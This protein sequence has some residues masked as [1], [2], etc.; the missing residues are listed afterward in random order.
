VTR[1]PYQRGLYHRSGRVHSAVPLD[2]VFYRLIRDVMPAGR[3]S[4]Y[5]EQARLCSRRDPWRFTDGLLA[6]RAMQLRRRVMTR[7]G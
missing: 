7:E 4:V 3:L 6:R 5:V 1:S 2:Y